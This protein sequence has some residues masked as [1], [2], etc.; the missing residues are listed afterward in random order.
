MPMATPAPDF[1]FG[2]STAP[3]TG[4]TPIILAEAWAD[5][6]ASDWLALL[7]LTLESPS[8]RLRT[9][10]GPVCATSVT[11]FLFVFGGVGDGVG[12]DSQ[13]GER[14]GEGGGME[15]E[16]G[17]WDVVHE[18]ARSL[19]IWHHEPAKIKRTGMLEPIIMLP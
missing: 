16:W 10:G 1:F 13:G 5:L 7:T 6:E 12:H 9:F 17:C 18:L 15:R 2:A 19:Y 11:V 4:G 14:G 3:P 8:S